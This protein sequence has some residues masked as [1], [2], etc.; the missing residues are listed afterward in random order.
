MYL[1]SRGTLIKIWSEQLVQGF[2][3][4]SVMVEST[5]YLVPGIHMRRM[6]L[7]RILYVPPSLL[8]YTRSP[9]YAQVCA[10]IVHGI[11]DLVRHA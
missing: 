11:R 9:A 6:Q 10:L 7:S 3:H 1:S 4:V 5:A 2:C 8:H